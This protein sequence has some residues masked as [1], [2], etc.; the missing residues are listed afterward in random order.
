[1]KDTQFYNR[2]NDL[3]SSGQLPPEVFALMST[4]REDTWDPGFVFTDNYAPFDLLM[5]SD[6][7][8]KGVPGMSQ[9]GT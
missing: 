6:V 1:M 9:P 4:H 2:L 7:I 3:V 5:G 8:D